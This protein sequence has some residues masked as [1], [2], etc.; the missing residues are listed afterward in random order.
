MRGP[1]DQDASEIN[2]LL[3]RLERE[4]AAADATLF[5]GAVGARGGGRCAVAR[6]EPGTS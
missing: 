2:A 3:E 5:V 6:G 1:M 4:D